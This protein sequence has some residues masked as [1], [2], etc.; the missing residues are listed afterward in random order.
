MLNNYLKIAVRNLFRHKLFSFINIFGL[1][2]G[3]S[4]GLLALMQVRDVL[5]YDRFHPYSERTYRILTDAHNTGGHRWRLA[6]APLPL[7]ELLS[8]EYGFVEKT[9]RVYYHTSLNGELSYGRKALPARGAFVDPGFYEVFGYRLAS[10]RPAVAPRTVLLTQETATRFFG[11]E[12]PLGKTLSGKD[13]GAFTVSGVLA[14]FPGKSH[15]QFDLLVSMAT[16]PLLNASAQVTTRTNDWKAV[17]FNYTYVRL[18]EGTPRAALDRILPALAVRARR[19]GGPGMDLS[20]AFRSQPFSNITPAWEDL[21]DNTWEPSV[22][23]L[24]SVAGM[25]L[26]ILLLA[27]F[28]YVNLTLARS[29]S[30]AREVGIRKVAGAHRSQ[31]VRQFLAESVLMTFLALWLAYFMLS[32]LEQL[33]GVQRWYAGGIPKDALLWLFFVVFALATGLLAG[34]MPARILSAYQP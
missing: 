28:N 33:P 7:S 6:S 15:L 9:A 14:P 16:L 26:V 11:R 17:D 4:V 10:G 8:R 18:R 25:A 21:H 5:E 3:M 27:G 23:M 13:L 19:E 12:N 30:R 24:L 2:T 22:G 1:A 32:L 34:L 29:L 20:Y 31:L